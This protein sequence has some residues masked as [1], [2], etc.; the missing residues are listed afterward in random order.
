MLCPRCK[1]GDL[2]E[3]RVKK[4]GQTLFICQECEA[5]WFSKEEILN[6]P[7]IDFGSYMMKIGLQPLWDEVS[8]VYKATIEA[9]DPKN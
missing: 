6:S 1:Q 5:T 3:A 8:V 4:T 2:V 9:P 7:F